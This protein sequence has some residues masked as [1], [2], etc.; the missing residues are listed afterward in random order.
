MT[1]LENHLLNG[2]LNLERKFTNQQKVL[3]EAQNELQKML[4]I[5][6]AENTQ[7]QKQVNNL[8]NQLMELSKL[9]KTNRR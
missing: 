8:S 3:S 7:L 2:L 9:Y 1:E 5:T 4:A 6:S